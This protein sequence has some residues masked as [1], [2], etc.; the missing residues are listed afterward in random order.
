MAQN[1]GGFED[2]DFS[3]HKLLRNTKKQ[4]EARFKTSTR[5]T[6]FQ[7]KEI[8]QTKTMRKWKSRQREV[9]KTN[10]CETGEE[11]SRRTWVSYS[12]TAFL[13]YPLP[14]LLSPFLP[15]SP[16]LYST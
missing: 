10:E 15:L 4:E 14:T 8:W 2:Q 16:P 5:R 7:M 12:R 13:T 6:I 11:A 1:G 3:F 9:K